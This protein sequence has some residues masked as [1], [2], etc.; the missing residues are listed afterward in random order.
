MR[1]SG[2]EDSLRLVASAAVYNV[3][4]S[5]PCPSETVRHV[6]NP[7][8]RSRQR[9]RNQ[10]LDGGKMNKL[11]SICVVAAALSACTPQKDPELATL[12]DSI[13]QLQAQ[14]T[15][16]RTENLKLLQRVGWLEMQQKWAQDTSS[17]L[18]V[19]DKGYSIAKTNLGDLLISVQDMTTYG[20]GVKLKLLVGNPGMVTYNGAKLNF[21]WGKAFDVTQSNPD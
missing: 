3:F 20:N 18:D 6:D 16:D 15:Q 10:T 1:F 19:T 12:S 2:D 4:I 17:M 21:K 9:V 11:M 8:C 14:A 13:K 5:P 7:R